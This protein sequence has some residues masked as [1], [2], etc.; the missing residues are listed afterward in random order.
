MSSRIV[1]AP[2]LHGSLPF[3]VSVREIFLRERPDC[4][5]VELPETLTTGV[6][7]AVRRLPLLSVLK[8]NVEGGPAFLLVEPCDGIFEALRL[9]REH[10]VPAHLVDRDSDH[11]EDRD[12]PMPD[13]YAME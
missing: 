10:E 5:A 4:V 1:Y 11:Y 12:E 7:R 8:Y 13:P 3:A 9:A 2:I 6:G